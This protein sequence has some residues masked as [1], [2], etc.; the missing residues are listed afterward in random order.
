ML[1][2]VNRQQLKVFQKPT[3][4]I[5]LTQLKNRYWVIANAPKKDPD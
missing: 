1:Q 2:N 4:F 5:R 3:K